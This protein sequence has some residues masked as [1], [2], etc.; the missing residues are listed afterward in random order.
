[1]P[2]DKQYKDILYSLFPMVYCKSR[3]NITAK[4]GGLEDQ[5]LTEEKLWD[6]YFHGALRK[7]ID[8]AYQNEWRLLLNMRKLKDSAQY[9]VKFF[10]VTKVFLGNR[11]PAK[12]RKEIIDICKQR[13][14]PYVGVTRSP[15]MFEMCDC[16]T[17][18]E[19]CPTFRTHLKQS[20][21]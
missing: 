20:S 1:M 6:I 11:M 15:N 10:P 13:N 12:N 17:L 21:R 16:K 2:D 4:L 5:P 18:C 7:S 9:N 3:P 14:I 19:D 8:W